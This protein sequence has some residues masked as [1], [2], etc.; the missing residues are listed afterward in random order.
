[1]TVSDDLPVLPYAGTSGWS[2]S[3][4]SY[5]RAVEQDSDG[6]T[7]KRQR[8]MLQFLGLRGARGCTWVEAS[9]HFNLHHGS[10]TGVL[11]T[12][13]KRGLVCR[14][15][16]RRG[17]SSVYVLPGF[18]LDRETAPHGRRRKEHCP[19]CGQPL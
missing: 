15:T 18:V 7:A 13:H 11:S 2:G 14:L 3:D 5:E 12:L 16:E 9:E 4:A 8:D 19:H 17:R 6:T 1:M 10:V